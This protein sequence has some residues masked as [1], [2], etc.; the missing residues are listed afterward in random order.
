MS[1]LAPTE[2]S[3]MLLLIALLPCIN[4]FAKTEKLLLLLLPLPVIMVLP[5]LQV[6]AMQDALDAWISKTKS[7]YRSAKHSLSKKHL[8]HL[9]CG[10]LL[11]KAQHS[12]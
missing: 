5:S 10:A 3:M 12:A 2:L 11:W 7:T 9:T 6:A 1:W 4:C 8:L